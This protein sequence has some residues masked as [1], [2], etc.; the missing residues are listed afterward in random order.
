MINKIGTPRRWSIVVTLRF[1]FLLLSYVRHNG[2][3]RNFGISWTS[4]GLCEEVIGL[5]R[6]RKFLVRSKGGKTKTTRGSRVII[7]EGLRRESRGGVRVESGVR[8]RDEGRIRDVWTWSIP[9]FFHSREERKREREFISRVNFFLPPEIA[10][11][12]SDLTRLSTLRLSRGI[13]SVELDAIVLDA[14]VHLSLSL[15]PFQSDLI[16]HTRLTPLR[17]LHDLPLSNNSVLLIGGSSLIA[18]RDFIRRSFRGENSVHALKSIISP[19][20]T[21]TQ[22]PIK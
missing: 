17:G 8:A 12:T 19:E 20:H 22:S 6:N 2:R 18:P 3:V 15:Y 9:V 14:P 13:G 10:R 21:H 11:A 7:D 16:H 1:T 4:G 5:F